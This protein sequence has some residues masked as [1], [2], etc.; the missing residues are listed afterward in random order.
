MPK[1]RVHLTRFHGVFA[2]NSHLRA[3]V[4]PAARGNRVGG[5]AQNTT[6][7]C[8]A[9]MSWAQRLKRVFDI[10]IQTCEHCGGAVRIIARIEDPAVIKTILEHRQ[11]TAARTPARRALPAARAPPLPGQLTE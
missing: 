3:Q 10:D 8:H 11:N 4:T 7:A 9:A 1:P 2:P 5:T 6:A